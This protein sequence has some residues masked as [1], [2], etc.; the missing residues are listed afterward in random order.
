VGVAPSETPVNPAQAIPISLA[1]LMPNCSAKVG[2]QV[3]VVRCPPRRET[4]LLR[5]PIRGSRP[6][7]VALP[8]PAKFCTKM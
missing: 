7:R 3:M 1:S 8:I 2:A 6:M 4:E 5:K